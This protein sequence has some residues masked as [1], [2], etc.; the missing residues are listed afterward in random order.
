MSVICL[1]IWLWAWLEP[2]SGVSVADFGHVNAC[3]TLVI[4]MTRFLLTNDLF[5]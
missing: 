2:S 3:W 5:D 4:L 1:Y